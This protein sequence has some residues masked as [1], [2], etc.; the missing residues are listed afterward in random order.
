MSAEEKA[1]IEKAQ[2]RIIDGMLTSFEHELFNAW[3]KALNEIKNLK[4]GKNG[5]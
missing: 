2:Q 5:T 3:L 1:L 4:A